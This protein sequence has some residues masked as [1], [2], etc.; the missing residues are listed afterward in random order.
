MCKGPVVE[1]NMVCL[2]NWKEAREAGTE[3]S[4][5]KGLGKW[6]RARPEG[7]GEEFPIFPFSHFLKSREEPLTGIKQEW[8]T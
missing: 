6:V 3:S 7:H 8:V 4:R 1:G 5:R 2:V